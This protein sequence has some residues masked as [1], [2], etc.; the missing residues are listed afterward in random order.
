[1]SIS[2]DH[3]EALL[4]SLHHSEECDSPSCDRDINQI[5]EAFRALKAEIVRLEAENQELA[6]EAMSKY[7]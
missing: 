1:M 4:R 7:Q 2:E 5:L 6:H 3:L